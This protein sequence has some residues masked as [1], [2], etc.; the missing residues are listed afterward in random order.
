MTKEK[1]LTFYCM[2]PEFTKTFP[3]TKTKDDLQAVS[4]TVISSI[5]WGGVEF[6]KRHVPGKETELIQ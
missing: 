2:L 6:H 3:Q 1:G 5:S 4:S